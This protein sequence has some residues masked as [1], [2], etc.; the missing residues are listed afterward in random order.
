MTHNTTALNRLAKRITT[1]ARVSTS[2]RQARRANEIARTV[3]RIEQRNVKQ[4][5]SAS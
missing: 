1:Y 5:R 4:T 3:N 2:V